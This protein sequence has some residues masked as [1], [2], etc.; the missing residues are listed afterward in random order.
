MRGSCL[1][2]WRY[3]YGGDVMIDIKGDLGA[4]ESVGNR[5]SSDVLYMLIYVDKEMFEK[6]YQ[7]L[8]NQI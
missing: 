2:D 4:G 6:C 1:T 5:K 8:N 3:Y 7:Q